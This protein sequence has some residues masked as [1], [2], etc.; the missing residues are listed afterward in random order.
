MEDLAEPGVAPGE[1][2]LRRPKA[3]DE[4]VTLFIPFSPVFDPIWPIF[5]RSVAMDVDSVASRM[6]QSKSCHSG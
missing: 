6:V 2:I 3:A 1:L 5:Q 4:L